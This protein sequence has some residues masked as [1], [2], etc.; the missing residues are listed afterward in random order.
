MQRTTDPHHQIAHSLFPQSNRAFDDP[1]AL[2]AADQVRAR[3]FFAKVNS[4]KL[5]VESC[6][7]CSKSAEPMPLLW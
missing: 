5:P 7:A 2:D 4:Q 3:A 1:A 6:F